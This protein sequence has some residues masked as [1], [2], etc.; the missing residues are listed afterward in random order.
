MK[1]L[2]LG[3]GPAGIAAAK[4]VRGKDKKS[5]I[6]VVTEELGPPYMRP[7]LTELIMDRVNVAGI[8]DPQAKVLDGQG[9]N[10]RHGKR[11]VKVD[12]PG[13]A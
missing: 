10:V 11:A 2:I 4:A 7:L 1:Y 12:L 5:E 8:A 6:V 9:I 3:C 13:T